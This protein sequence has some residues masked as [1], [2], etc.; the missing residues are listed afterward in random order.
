MPTYL[1]TI[2]TR[3]FPG[4]GERSPVSATGLVRVIRFA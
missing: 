2:V 1:Q 3:S 4:R